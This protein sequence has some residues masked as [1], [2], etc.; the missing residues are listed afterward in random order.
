MTRG[1]G[2]GR[3]KEWTCSDSAIVISVMKNRF[4]ISSV[5]RAL[6]HWLGG[7]LWG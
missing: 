2:R 5:V 6:F 1:R 3:T 4:S 7:G